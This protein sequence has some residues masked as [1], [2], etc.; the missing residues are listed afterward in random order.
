MN[1]TRLV[2][3]S[4]C[5]VIELVLTV[6]VVWDLQKRERI[7]SVLRAFLYGSIFLVLTGPITSI[8]SSCLDQNDINILALSWWLTTYNCVCNYCTLV[9]YVL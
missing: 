1:I 4:L 2:I 9:W 3:Y 7:N 5:L 8:I 6:L